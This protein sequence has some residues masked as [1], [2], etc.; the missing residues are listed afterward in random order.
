MAIQTFTFQY[1][2]TTMNLFKNWILLKSEF[3]FQYGATTIILNYIIFQQ[4]HQFTF[5]YG[6]TTI[7]CRKDKLCYR[8]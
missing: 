4:I 6:A 5:Q 8:S 3:T 1:G 2:A 7:R